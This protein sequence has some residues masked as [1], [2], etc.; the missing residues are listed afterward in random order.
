MQNT[1]MISKPLSLLT[2]A[3]LLALSGCKVGPDYTAVQPKSPPPTAFTHTGGEGFEPPS[4]TKPG[5][6]PQVEWWKVLNDPKLDDLVQRAWN[7]NLDLRLAT[8]RIREARAQRG[9]I[10]PQALPQVDASGSASRQRDSRNTHQGG[11]GGSGDAYNLFQAGFDASWEIDVFGRVARDVEAAD[12]DIQSAQEDRRAVLV[13]LVSEVARNYVELR[14]FQQRLAIARKNIQVQQ[15]TLELTKNRFKAGLVS[16]LD[17]AQAESSLSTTESVVPPLDAAVQASIH[18][19][20]VLL[21]RQPTELMTEL[22]PVADIPTPPAEIPVG[23][24]SDLLRRRPDIRRAERDVAAATARIGVATADLYP[25]FS[26]TGSFGF[27]ADKVPS[28]PDASSRFWSFGPSVRWPILDWGRIR[29]NIAVQ[30]ARTEQALVRF[31]QAVLGS[32]EDVEDALVAYSRE[33][34]RL[35]S[36]QASVTS[37]RRAFEVANKLYSSGVSD[38]QRVLDTQRSLFASEDALTESQ[39]VVATKLVAVYKALGGG[40]EKFTPEKPLAKP[41]L[42]PSSHWGSDETDPDEPPANS[43]DKASVGNIAKTSD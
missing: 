34:A 31:E 29:S 7:G 6:P 16:D 9:V 13:T 2:A 11:F 28:L 35:R 43:A 23:L 20:G 25:R 19:I 27:A 42:R 36:L 33:Q 1:N 41:R 30:D 14:G 32:F 15:S 5:E 40:W 12:A 8:A 39:K 3:S 10:A 21:G 38:F 18:R 4:V 37:D 17:V 22:S 24:P 26:L